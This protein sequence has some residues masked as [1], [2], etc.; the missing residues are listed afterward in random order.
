MAGELA[1]EIDRG[2]A[3]IEN[4]EARALALVAEGPIVQAYGEALDGADAPTRYGEASLTESFA[5]AFALFRADPQ[6][7]ERVAPGALRWFRAG[8]HVTSSP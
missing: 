2:T 7:L 1:G 4:L 3:R 6:A 5:E 8:R